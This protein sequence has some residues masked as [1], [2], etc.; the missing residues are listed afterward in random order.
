MSRGDWGAVAVLA[1]AAAL[2]AAGAACASRDRQAT[3]YLHNRTD[4]ER[5]RQ[6]HPELVEPNYL[7]FMAWYARI[8]GEE[9]LFFCRWPREA[10]P[11]AVKVGDLEIGEALQDEFHPTPPEAFVAAAARALSS[12]ES[13]LEGLVS[14][15]RVDSPAEAD[16]VLR[17]LGEEAPVPDPGVKVLG[18]TPLGD[19]CRLED[20][21]WWKRLLGAP[22][23]GAPDGVLE[24][25]FAVPELRVYV[26]DEFGLLNPDQV[27]RIALH[28]IGHALGMRSHSPVPNDLMFQRVLERPGPARLSAEDVNSFVSLYTL[29]NGAIYRR[30]PEGRQT[31]PPPEPAPGPPELS[32]AP[33]VD[34]Q[35]GFEMQLPAGWLKVD[36]PTGFVAV[37]GTTWDYSASLQLIVRRFPTLESYLGRHARAHVRDGTVL[38]QGDLVVAD[39]PAFRLRVESADGSL[40]DEH[41]FIEAGDGR[42]FISIADCAA[43]QCSAYWPWFDAA[44]GTLEIWGREGGEGSDREYRRGPGPR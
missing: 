22:R 28:E 41:I 39:H 33:H 1:A 21:P 10:F 35:R 36:T 20:P 43:D 7:P 15:R 23:P 19:A 18:T 42:V 24:P 29:P 4:Y 44:L 9:T 31:P 11:L 8:A 26:A 16:L 27:E 32:L 38:D 12:W 40:V 5:F 25:R 2:L 17:L 30:L 6:R 13:E 34:A 37:D 14:F 3:R